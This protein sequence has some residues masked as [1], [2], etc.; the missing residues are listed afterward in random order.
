MKA[1][2]PGWDGEPRSKLSALLEDEVMA[3]E[4]AAYLDGTLRGA[5]LDLIQGLIDADSDLAREVEQLRR[6]NMSLKTL[7]AEIID[8]PIPD[9]L[10][11]TVRNGFDRKK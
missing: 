3:E 6:V 11:A 4:L 9:S 7:G 2:V 1:D 5:R 10:L 8:E